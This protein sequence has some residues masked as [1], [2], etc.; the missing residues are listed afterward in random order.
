MRETANN[1]NCSGTSL[2]DILQSALPPDNS[3][4]TTSTNNESTATSSSICN[5]TSS[6]VHNND[7]TNKVKI[8]PQFLI[9]FISI[10]K[11]YL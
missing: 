5:S 7:L 1:E 2:A 4:T 8:Y 3:S 10:E 11:I 9:L 6:L